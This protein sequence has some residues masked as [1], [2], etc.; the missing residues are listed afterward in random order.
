MERDA[1]TLYQRAVR[2]CELARTT[3][4]T[5]GEKDYAPAIKVIFNCYSR[6][7]EADISKVIELYKLADKLGIPAAKNSLGLYYEK[8]EGVKQDGKQAAR[9]YQEAADLNYLPAIC[10]LANCYYYAQGV[11]ADKEKALAQ[12]T[13]LY[14]QISSS[15]E[16][17]KTAYA[18]QSS[19]LKKSKLAVIDYKN[20]AHYWEAQ[21]KR[22]Q[23]R[24]EGLNQELEEL[25]AKLRKR[26]QQLFGRRTEKQVSTLQS[27]PAKSA[28]KLGQQAN[29][30]I[31]TRRDYRDLPE[32]EEVVGLNESENY[33]PCCHFTLGNQKNFKS[34]TSF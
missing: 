19:E 12:F 27:A 31:P 4:K 10:N 24:E 13:E 33:C 22:I 6:G 26:E 28:K 11:K 25:K 8:G 17:L 9:L 21:F 32:V 34:K 7:C 16:A 15:Y 1:K 18:E 20:Q 2:F 14:Q 29:N 5:K 23:T 30:P 3:A